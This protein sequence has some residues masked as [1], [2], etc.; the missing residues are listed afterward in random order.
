MSDSPLPTEPEQ[1]SPP[2][3]AP[4]PWEDRARSALGRFWGTFGNALAP[5][6]GVPALCSPAVTPAFTFAL[7]SALPMMLASGIVPY[8]RTLTFGPSLRTAPTAL[9]SEIPLWV[10]VLMS[11]GMGGAVTLI[12]QLSWALPF[13]SLLRAFS[14]PRVPAEL[15]RAIGVRFALYRA[16]LVPAGLLA[17]NLAIWALP[18]LMPAP[19]ASG[20]EGGLQ[21]TSAHLLAFVVF[22]LVPPILILLGAQATA[23][24]LGAS[25]LGA[26]AVAV[27]PAIMQVTVGLIVTHYMA[28][29]LLPQVAK[30]L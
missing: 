6:R 26:L 27:V 19:D 3:I 20:A 16:W 24:S 17:M 1:G 10:D 9:A 23:A 21:P 29:W 5:M 4:M 15:V 13:T 18:A 11:M 7:L 12:A 22:Q 28:A 2:P 30:A 14:D 8:T 25:S